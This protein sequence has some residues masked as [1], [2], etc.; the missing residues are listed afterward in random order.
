MPRPPVLNRWP[1]HGR[2][3]LSPPAARRCRKDG[4]GKSRRRVNAAE[5]QGGRHCTIS[6][7]SKRQV[8]VTFS[9]S[10]Q[11]AFR[12]LC[13]P[14][15]WIVRVSADWPP[16]SRDQPSRP[17]GRPPCSPEV[18]CC[19]SAIASAAKRI[20]PASVQLARPIPVLIRLAPTTGCLATS[21]PCK[22]RRMGKT[23][24]Q[25][26]RQDSNPRPAA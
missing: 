19:P 12:P 8:P 9:R 26:A 3:L 16:D 5:L 21:H 18:I 23:A 20:E 4:A 2:D 22:R 14:S 7:A 1:A 17:M 6:T 11:R 10:V 15:C 25:R 13:R 24:G